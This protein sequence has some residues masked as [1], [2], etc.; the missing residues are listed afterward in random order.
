VPA[1]ER[2]IAPA[3]PPPPGWQTSSSGSPQTW[4]GRPAG[5]HSMR[6]RPTSHLTATYLGTWAYVESKATGG[7]WGLTEAR[8][9]PQPRGSGPWLRP[10]STG[11]PALRHVPDPQRWMARRPVMARHFPCSGLASHATPLKPAGW[12]IP[13]RTPQLAAALPA[14][15][16]KDRPGEH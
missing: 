10:G 1:A 9:G 11:I 16:L 3:A 6:R 8:G 12:V 4:T 5:V 15:G 2:G 7:H 14:R 13:R